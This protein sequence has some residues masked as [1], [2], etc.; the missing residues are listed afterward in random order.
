M[1]EYDDHKEIIGAFGE[2]QR[3]ITVDMIVAAQE[4]M[5]RRQREKE[6]TFAMHY[7]AGANRVGQ[8]LGVDP[9]DDSSAIV[10]MYQDAAITSK[11][12]DEAK[13]LIDNLNSKLTRL[14]ATAVE[15]AKKIREL[16]SFM[17]ASD[18]VIGK[19]VDENTELKNEKGLSDDERSMLVSLRDQ[20]DLHE[21][22]NHNLT[23]ENN[24]L[25]AKLR[26]AGIQP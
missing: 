12:D 1:N 19:L 16:T 11:A 20:I 10:S 6:A 8:I 2:S 26:E 4:A 7:G 21:Q 25:R 23:E 14:K 9:A 15:D 17:E 24:A 5:E 3:R 18:K 22:D 13:K